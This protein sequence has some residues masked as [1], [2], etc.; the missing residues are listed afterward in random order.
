MK[1]TSEAVFEMVIKAHL[2]NSGYV[3]VAGEEFDRSH[4]I[5]PEVA[6]AFICETQ[7]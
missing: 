2:L 1:R 6:L 5:F 3:R 7:P 4:A